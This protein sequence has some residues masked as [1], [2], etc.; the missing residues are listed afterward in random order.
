MGRP[1]A[2]VSL[3]LAVLTAFACAQGA[4]A[5]GQD[6][7]IKALNAQRAA[8][9]LPASV[10]ENTTASAGCAAHDSYMHRNNVFGHG[11]DPSLPG[12][13]TLGDVFKQ[14]FGEVLASGRNGGFADWVATG[15]GPWETAP[16]HLFLLLDPTVG[17]VGADES[18]GFDCMRLAWNGAVPSGF[19]SYPGP[20]RVD[21]PPAEHAS[22]S[23]YVPQE[24][25]GIPADQTTGPEHPSL[26]PCALSS[27]SVS[28]SSGVVASQLAGPA[29]VDFFYNG[30]DLIPVKPLGY[31]T[32]YTVSA[33]WACGTQSFSFTTGG[34]ANQVLLNVDDDNA[35]PNRV[36]LRVDSDAPSGSA[37][38][39][40]L[41][42]QSLAVTLHEKDGSLLSKPLKLPQGHYK[43]CAT[44]GSQESGYET[45][46]DCHEFDHAGNGADYLTVSKLVRRGATVSITVEARGP[47]LGQKLWITGT[48]ASGCGQK[49]CQG[50]IK[51]SERTTRLKASQTFSFPAPQ[52]KAQLD[53]HL[54]LL[55]FT[56]AGI[57]YRGVEIDRY[58][59][60]H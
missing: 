35:V 3:A 27:A 21:V 56:A 53:V 33:N 39:T 50:W 7:A 29:Q 2:L 34:R 15:V 30:G 8:N 57:G 41:G 48:L 25:V 18:D 51:H 49:W 24:K 28:S 42:G 19:Y 60:V 36:V 1:S 11:E 37:T 12:Y 4:A 5:A 58:A 47:A 40:G 45:A 22:E 6:V 54:L 55:D 17:A 9:G 23:P 52:G 16:I 44:T 14:P 13:S 32:R 59:N 31:F 38:L 46:G 26:G 10:V 43:A 20:D